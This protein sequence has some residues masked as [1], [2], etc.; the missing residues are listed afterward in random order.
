MPPRIDVY[1]EVGTKRVFASALDW[2]GWC[3][4]ARDGDA[5]L[6]ALAVYGPRYKKALGRKARGFELPD[7]ASSFNVVERLKGDGTTDFGVPG[8]APT[9]DERPLEEAEANRLTGL[10]E[11]CWAAFDAAAE[12]AS[13]VELRKG[14]RGGGR[15]LDAIVRHLMEADGAYLYQLGGRY[16]PAS[17]GDVAAEIAALRKAILDTLHPR[18]HGDSL[19]QS[20]RRKSKLWSP[21]YTVRRSAWHALDHAWEIE[22]RATI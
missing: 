18:A 1:L 11:G 6:E 20:P 2:P 22:D 13:S 17:D 9:A 3:R 5:A 16:R 10:L 14:P 8:K 4:G 15:G 7:A 21:R 19:P 12:D